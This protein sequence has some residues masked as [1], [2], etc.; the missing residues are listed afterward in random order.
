MLILI[1][2]LGSTSLKYQLLDMSTER[3]VARG[4]V[5]RI[6]SA[7]AIV[8]AT[9]GTGIPEQTTQPVADHR[10]AIQLLV[11]HLR[12]DG[13]VGIDAV[14]FKAVIGGPQYRGSFRVDADLL[15]AMRE[16][17][18]VAPV[19][20]AVYISAMEIFQDLL[21]GTPMVAV[22]EPGFH[23]TMPDRA[24][25]YGVPYEWF[26]DHGVRRYGF[27]GSSHRYVAGR[28]PELLGRSPADL[29]LVSC[30]LG[31]SSS[32]CAVQHGRSIDCSFGFSPQSGVDHAARSGELDPFAVFY[33]M[34]KL[35]LTESRV[36][37]LLT[38][39]GGL[40]GISGVSSDLRDI[41]T[42]A[43]EGNPRA[44][45]AVDVLAYQV[46]K[47]IG[48]YAAA[49]GGLDAIAF[50]GGIGE[51]SSRVRHLVCEGLEFLGVSLDPEANRQRVEHDR[52]ISTAES[53]VAV[54]IVFT[55][56]EI[57]VARESVRVLMN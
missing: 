45:L 43:D 37:E 41:E 46:K 25:V 34:D 51:N 7:D 36:R 8:S 9:T 21:P 42:A 6:G 57:V 39:N 5:E 10:A 14:G 52:T 4:K 44:A 15:A 1:P 13:S 56:E 20:N 11:E 18:P 49:M 28:A 55:N 24:A 12:R 2:N 26:Q 3:V 23:A 35:E 22:F 31:G 19:H 50:A 27:H 47:Y 38:K 33:M 16:F 48:A 29:R 30:H 54:A 32:I 17:L 40:L 53:R